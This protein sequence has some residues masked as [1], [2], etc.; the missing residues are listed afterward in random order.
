[1][2]LRDDSIALNLLLPLLPLCNT[3]PY[4]SGAKPDWGGYIAAT[5]AGQKEC[6]HGLAVMAPVDLAAMASM[7]KGSTWRVATMVGMSPAAAIGGWVRS[8]RRW[9]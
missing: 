5:I 6:R 4:E 1:M 2:S 8:K 7:G 9:G 3:E